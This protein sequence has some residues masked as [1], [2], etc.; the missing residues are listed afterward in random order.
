MN[1]KA[2][3]IPK[4]IN[5]VLV[6]KLF[7]IIS[8]TLLT[9]VAAQI[10]IPFKPVPFTLQTVM[11]V[12]SGAFLGAKNGAYSQLLYLALGCLGLP[13]FAQI[14]ASVGFMRLF[15]PTGG[16]LLSFPIAA[17]LTGYMLEI[18]KSYINITLTMFL[19]NIFIIAMGT[20]FLDLF[21]IH[22]IIDSIKFGAAIF[23]I[24]TVVKIFLSINIYYFIKKPGKSV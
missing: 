15:G 22:N 19:A 6:S 18:N 7:G 16:Y 9:A 12:L 20:L 11:V 5:D 4:Y 13:V 8:F 14:P 3:V 21:Y 10:T 2:I 24:W 1:T 17:Y 23:S